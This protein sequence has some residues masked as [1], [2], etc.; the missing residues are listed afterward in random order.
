M[1]RKLVHERLTWGGAD[2]SYVVVLENLKSLG[3]DVFGRQT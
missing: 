3:R 2:V 1:T